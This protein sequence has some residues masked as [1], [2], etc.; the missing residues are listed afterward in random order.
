V[1]AAGFGQRHNRFANKAMRE[2][3]FM[4]S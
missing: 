3:D 1:V 4:Q 2:H